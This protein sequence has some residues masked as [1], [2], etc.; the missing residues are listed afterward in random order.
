MT[1]AR[2]AAQFGVDA[3]ALLATTADEDAAPKVIMVEDREVILAGGLAVLRQ[4][5]P[6]ATI[7]GFEWGSQAIE[8]ARQNRVALAFLDIEWT[9]SSA[10]RA[11]STCAAPCST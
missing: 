8:F 2:L 5:M 10:A 9:L 6:D 7:T 3:G 4:V 1:I 11:G